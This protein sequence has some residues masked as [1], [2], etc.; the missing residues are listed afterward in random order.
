M[1]TPD[2]DTPHGPE[3]TVILGVGASVASFKAI[4]VLRSLAAAGVNVWVC[5]TVDS[6]NFVGKATWESLSG[7]P[8]HTD[9]FQTP[10]FITH[11]TL[12]SQ[13]DLFLTVGASADLMARF[14]MGLADEF[15]TLVAI[16]VDCPCLIAP[17]MHPTMWENAATQDNVAVLRDRGWR[18]IGPE[19]GKL[20]D[21][22]YGIGRLSEPDVI[23]DAVLAQL[24]VSNPGSIS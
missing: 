5:P 4:E 19:T 2:L 10:D 14:R 16:T 13:A 17:S 9:V 6:L 3:K 11:V 15:L 1:T 20:A 23:C 24:G 12:A 7:H 22:T 21:N 18:F 8:I